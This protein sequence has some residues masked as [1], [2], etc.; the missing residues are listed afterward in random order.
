MNKLQFIP[1]K[2]LLAAVIVLAILL[3]FVQLGSVPASL[4]WDEVSIGYNAYS[5]LQI[6][7]DEYG[8]FMPAVF[9]SFDDYKPPLYEYLDILPVWVFGLDP[10]AVRF[11]AAV[12]GTLAVL[13]VFFLVQELLGLVKVDSVRERWRCLPVLAALCLAISPWHVHF[14]RVAFEANIGVTLNIGFVVCFLKGLKRWGWLIPSA[15]LAVLALYAYHSERLFMPL[16]ALFLL[17]YFRKQLLRFKLKLLIP[18]SI[19]VIVLFPLLLVFSNPVNW[20][21]LLNT[22]SVSKPTELLAR[23]VVKLAEDEAKGDTISRLLFDN[24][25]IVYVQKIIQGYLAHFSLSWLF[26][27]ADNLRHHAPGMGLLYLADLPFFFVGLYQLLKNGAGMAVVVF[28]WFFISPI[29]AS[30]T[31]ELPHAVRTLVFLPTFQI[32]IAI[33][34]I[35]ALIWFAA[36]KRWIL[37]VCLALIIGCYAA[38]VTYYLHM[39]YNHMDLEYSE[40]WQYGYKEAVD[41]V[42]ANGMQ[43]RQVIIS[44]KLSQAYMFFLFYLEYS[45]SRYQKEGGSA[46][47]RN[48]YGKY[49]FQPVDWQTAVPDPGVL[50]IAAAPEI[51]GPALLTIKNL[52]GTDAIKIAVK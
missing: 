49:Y 42:K 14:S 15:V 45:P 4:D 20:T 38:N 24:S 30:P 8:A 31:S 25:R 32:F 40:A 41:Y 51:P 6:G 10:W 35:E 17:L 26:L 39:Y 47:G 9:R 37:Q 43:Y 12:M 23:T 2:Y 36:R 21:R 11:P 1:Q 33:G 5:L 48:H 50:Y 34:L 13:G 29:A 44:Q 19:G 18:V 52:D 3:R 22:S 16:L 28:F 27:T 46:S 7:R